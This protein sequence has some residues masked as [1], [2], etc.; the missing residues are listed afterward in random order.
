MQVPF[1]DIQNTNLPDQQRIQEDYRRMLED[2]LAIKRKA[3]AERLYTPQA[4]EGL[5]ASAVVAALGVGNPVAFTDIHP[6]D[7]IL[8]IGCGGGI[9]SLLAAQ[10]V[11][12]GGEVIGVDMTPEMLRLARKNAEAAGLSNLEF[13]EGMA[14]DMSFIPDESLDEVISN[15]V[16]NLT[17]DKKR[18]FAEIQ[19]VLR[20]GGCTVLSDIVVN[21]EI[22][23]E[24]LTNPAAWSG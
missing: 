18:V 21:G 12:S 17:S 22:P 14:E 2:A 7:R 3:I 10:R 6:G 20:A 19:R 11:G 5:P 16:I 13:V 23:P 8:D 1:K 15:G 24:V 9:D 4:L